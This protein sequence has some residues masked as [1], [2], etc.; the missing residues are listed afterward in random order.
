MYNYLSPDYFSFHFKLHHFMLLCSCKNTPAEPENT[1][2]PLS[3]NIPAS[4]Y[5]KATT[6][7]DVRK[8]NITFTGYP[9]RQAN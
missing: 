3:P 6:K 7:V 9:M 1:T 5:T 2:A 4:E 8:E